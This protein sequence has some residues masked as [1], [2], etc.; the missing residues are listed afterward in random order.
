MNKSYE[1]IDNKV[2]VYDEYYHASSRNYTNNIDDVLVTENNIEEIKKIIKE[3]KRKKKDINI[4]E[5]VV[6]AYITLSISRL[7][8][9]IF[10]FITHEIEIAFISLI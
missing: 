6:P 4:M 8:S 5:A 7:I 10:K 2:I 3:E 9:S 1:V